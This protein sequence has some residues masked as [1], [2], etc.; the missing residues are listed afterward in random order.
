MFVYEVVISSKPLYC[1]SSW[2]LR[3]ISPK[4]VFNPELGGSVIGWF[5]NLSEGILMDPFPNSLSHVQ[6]S[7]L[8]FMTKFFNQNISAIFF[9]FKVGSPQKS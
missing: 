1:M 3:R 8:F 9:A 5:L 2:F 7:F 4:E 6:R